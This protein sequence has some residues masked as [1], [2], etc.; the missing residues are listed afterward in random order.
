[1]RQRA[2]LLFVGRSTTLCVVGNLKTLFCT[3]AAK[4]QCSCSRTRKPG[5]TW[6]VREGSASLAALYR[7]YMRPSPPFSLL[8]ARSSM[9]VLT[10]SGLA[11]VPCGLFRGTP[12]CYA[13]H[14]SRPSS[15]RPARGS[16]YGCSMGAMIESSHNKYSSSS[17]VSSMQPPDLSSFLPVVCTMF[18]H[19]A[20]RSTIPQILRSW[21][22]CSF[23]EGAATSQLSR[24]VVHP[25]AVVVGRLAFGPMWW[26]TQR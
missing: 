4:K 17:Y 16:R 9:M 18:A 13:T 23:R 15:S 20:K 8:L 5:R 6:W 10:S 22:A 19:T 26:E 14:R 3:P 24:F 21:L 12:L 7:R 11:L 2:E 25:L 1:M